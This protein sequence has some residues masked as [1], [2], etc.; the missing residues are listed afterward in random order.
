MKPTVI[1]HHRNLWVVYDAEFPNVSANG[2]T[3]KEAIKNLAADIEYIKKFE[4]KSS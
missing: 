2:R 4:K 1:K 3:K